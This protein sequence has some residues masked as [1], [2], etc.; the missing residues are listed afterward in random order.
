MALP[1]NLGAIFFL[2][3][4]FYYLK[5]IK[6]QKYKYFYAIKATVFIAIAS[7]IHPPLSLFNFFFL[8]IFLKT[9]KK[10]DFIIIIILNIF[11][12]LPAIIFLYFKGLFF[13]NCRVLMFHY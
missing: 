1:I 3:S 5:F 4:I 10:Y 2:I 9:L 13:L 8:Y 7:Y 12:S 11:F 6:G